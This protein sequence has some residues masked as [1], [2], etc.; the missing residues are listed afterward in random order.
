MKFISSFG[1]EFFGSSSDL[2]SDFFDAF[3]GY[4]LNFEHAYIVRSIYIDQAADVAGLIGDEL[5]KNEF[6][7]HIWALS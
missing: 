5:S 6:A 1:F 7:V 4:I 3:I 2:I